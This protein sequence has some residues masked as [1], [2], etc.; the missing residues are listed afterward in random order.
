MPKKN[1]ISW[2]DIDKLTKTLIRKIGKTK[3]DSILG[4]TRGGLIPAVKISHALNIPLQPVNYHTRDFEAMGYES[5][6]IDLMDEMLND[7]PKKYL[8]IDDI[9]DSGLTI[10][11]L[12]TEFRNWNMN[13]EWAVLHDN[14]PSEAKVKYFA[15]KIDKSKDPAW[16]VYPW[17]K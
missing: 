16:I 11:E 8:A 10:N 4:I 5:M 17:E 14:K 1:Y 15:K 7:P 9:N 2:Q 6:G 13:V 12:S 3:Y